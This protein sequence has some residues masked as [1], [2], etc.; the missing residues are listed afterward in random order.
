MS[1]RLTKKLLLWL[2]ARVAVEALLYEGPL[3]NLSILHRLEKFGSVRLNPSTA[4]A[5]YNNNGLIYIQDHIT[6]LIA[7]KQADLVPLKIEKARY[8]ALL[9]IMEDESNVPHLAN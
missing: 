2:R 3:P 9:S 7:Q 4:F 1:E 6:E 5:R 8:D